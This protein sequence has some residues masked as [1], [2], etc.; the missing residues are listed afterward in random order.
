MKIRTAFFVV[1]FG[2]PLQLSALEKT[3]ITYQVFQFP[4]N[5]IPR[6]DGQTD[7]WA[8]VSSTYVIGTDQLLG[9]KDANARGKVRSIE[10]NVRV[11]WVKGLNRLYFLYEAEDDYW[12]FALPGLHNDT[13]EVVV[14]ADASGGPL[15]DKGH[16]EF[17]TAE[18]VGESAAASE[19][20]INI[21]Q[22]HWAIHG[23]HAQNY[24]IF[25]P[26]VDKDWALAWGAPTWIKEFPWANAA[27]SF[28]FKPSEKG[29]LV[30]EFW[31]TPFDYAGPEGPH[32]AIESILE[33]NKIIGLGW[34][35]IDY[36]DVAAREN[37]GFWTLSP[38]RTMYGHASQL[39]AFRLMPIEPSLQPEL[40]AR[41]TWK[42]VSHDRRVVAFMD[43]SIGQVTSWKWDFGDGKTSTEQHPVHRYAK[44]DNYVVILEVHG[45][46]G[47]SRRSKV[48]DVQL[49]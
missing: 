13:F 3:E 8:N 36:D 38:Q 1:L 12:D 18:R 46:A 21:D 24:H 30:L 47:A 5:Q 43:E 44:P 28:S 48:W 14:D 16:K 2:I 35:I 33:E 34:I 31:I 15:I 40:Q 6:I 23:V 29:K 32:R 25:T 10:A 20:R 42:V 45:P 4:A 11:G 37:N 9:S 17:W 7:D 39:C 49:K 19:D 26:A 41:W 27:Y 22:A